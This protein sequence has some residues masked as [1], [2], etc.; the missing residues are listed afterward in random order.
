MKAAERDIELDS[1]VGC[2]CRSLEFAYKL[3]GDRAFRANEQPSLPTHPPEHLIAVPV[4]N[5][6]FSGRRRVCLQA[7]GS[8]RAIGWQ[9]QVLGYWVTVLV[10]ALQYSSEWLQCG[11]LRPLVASSLVRDSQLPE[12]GAPVL[13]G[14]TTPSLETKSSEFRRY[15]FATCV[16]SDF[17]CIYS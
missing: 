3:G 9:S 10:V 5:S 7:M 15:L 8:S 12:A 2:S 17:M 1:S 14:I 13:Q 4:Q 11:A 6:E 16:G